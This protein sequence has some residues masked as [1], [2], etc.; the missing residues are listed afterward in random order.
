MSRGLSAGMQTAIAAGNVYPVLFGLFD[1]SGGEVRV[2]THNEDITWDGHTWSGLGELVSVEPMRE[3]KEVRANGL[4]FA[5]NGVP[6]SL[7]SEVIA[8]R[9]RGRECALWFGC[10]NSSG[11]LIT[12]PHKIF[13]GRMDQPMIED[14]GD[15]CTV[16]LSAEG[17]LVDLQRSRERRYT[18]EDQQAEYT[19]DL[20]LQYVAGLQNKEILWG[21]GKS[22]T[23]PAASAA[24]VGGSSGGGISSGGG[25]GN[26]VEY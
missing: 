25:Y 16:S 12:D 1:F 8:N 24:G 17:R 22:S 4:T 9:S 18:D 21:Q 3:S 23:T 26:T 7:I 2:C 11:A 6:S 15:K 19:G 10:F 14:T 5:L 20:G 13:A